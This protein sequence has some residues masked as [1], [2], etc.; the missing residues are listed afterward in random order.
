MTSTSAPRLPSD[1]DSW[2]L[3]LRPAKDAVDAGRPHAYLV[4]PERAQNGLIEDVATLFLTNRECPF[5]CLMCDLWKYT[6]DE[7]VS[8]GAISAQIEWALGRLPPVRHV[9]LYNAGS[10]FDARAIPSG[11]LP[12]IAGQLANLETVIVE[13]HPRL[14]G[15]SCLAFQESLRPALQVAMG[16]ET[17]HPGV[18]PRLNK[19][20]TLDDFE[21]AVK[22]L[23]KH[24]IEVRAFILLRPPYL[25]ESE[26]LLWAKRSIDFAF[27]LGVECCVVIPTRTGNGAMEQL[28]ERGL[29]TRPRLRSLEEAVE[30]G[31]GLRAGRVFADLW[32][33]QKFLNC[34]DCDAR[35]AERLRTM[36]LTQSVAP[37]V[38]CECRC[39]H[40]S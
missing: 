35:R 38:V 7:R 9:K 6:T 37:S 39:L 28:Q 12:R 4:E 1:L 32:D 18:L 21:Q 33:I 40:D 34:V 20:M 29:F 25:D 31:I 3:S 23:K 24:A 15:R 22:L 2:I 26:G 5:R 36:N 11:D 10:F 17:V 30:Y 13:C 16:L 8:D 27:A 19:R 14:V